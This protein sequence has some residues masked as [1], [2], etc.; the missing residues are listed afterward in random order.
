MNQHD[1]RNDTALATF[2]ISEMALVIHQLPAIALTA[3]D[4][5]S[6]TSHDKLILH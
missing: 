4:A 3:S 2:C 5:G 1:K 6:H